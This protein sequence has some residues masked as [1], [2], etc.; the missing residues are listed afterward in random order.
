MVPRLTHFT[1]QDCWCRAFPH[2]NSLAFTARD[3]KNHVYIAVGS[4]IE[5]A[6]VS[7]RLT[8]LISWPDIYET[9]AIRPDSIQYASSVQI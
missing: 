2:V 3:C 6:D 7:V 5:E 8:D 9:L 1:A 4:R